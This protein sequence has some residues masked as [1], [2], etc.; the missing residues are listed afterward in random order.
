MYALI[1]FSAL[2]FIMTEA[3]TNQPNRVTNRKW[4][5]ERRPEG[6]FHPE[7]DVKMVSEEIELKCADDEVIVETEMLSADAF[8][9]TMLDEEAYHGSVALRQTIPSLGYGT[10]VHAG[11]ATKY[12]VGSSVQGLLGA[13]TYCTVK[14]G[15]IMT[16]INLPFM[17]ARAS[18]GIMSLTC[19]LTAYTGMFYVCG[20]P[21]KGDTVV[22]TG[23][24]GA[25]GSV[26][27]QLAKSTGARGMCV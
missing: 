11:S 8:I 14:T 7:N 24:T 13:E 16:K 18:L 21:K 27:A 9:R 19:G 17:P 26:A 25:V 12:K 3:S 22:V 6:V 23:A 1:I 2:I 10:V 20:K 15:Q 5:L 4:V